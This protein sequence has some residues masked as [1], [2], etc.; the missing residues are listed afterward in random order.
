MAPGVDAT[1]EPLTWRAE[2]AEGTQGAGGHDCQLLVFR[3]RDTKT[4]A[5][6]MAELIVEVQDGGLGIGQRSL[7]G[8]NSRLPSLSCNAYAESHRTNGL[9][10][11]HGYRLVG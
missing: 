7:R 6:L 1:V 3:T 11:M 2:L 5:V 10:Y 4:S 8:T 9:A